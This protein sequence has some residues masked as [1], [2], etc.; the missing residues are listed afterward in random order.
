GRDDRD[1]RDAPLGPLP[2]R[3][4]GRDGRD[5]DGLPGVR[6]RARA[7]GGDQGHASRDR[8]GRRPARAL[9]PRGAGRRA[10]QPPVHRRRHRRGRGR[11][12]AVHRL[13]VRRGR[14]AEG[15]HPPPRPP[16]DPGGRRLR[17]RDRPGARRRARPRDR[18]PRRQAPERP[19][20]RGGLGEGHGLRDRP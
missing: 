18:P 3:P 1:G 6:H 7:P 8:R 2:P 10:A 19:G 4:A 5:V 13:R 12:D 16:A 9:P 14:D 11:R 15:P 17:H 20:G